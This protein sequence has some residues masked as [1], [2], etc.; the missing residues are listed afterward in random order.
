ML[1]KFGVVN[2]LEESSVLEY[3]F[4]HW[5]FPVVL[6]ECSL[7]IFWVSSSGPLGCE[8]EG[9]TIL[10]KLWEPLAQQRNGKSQKT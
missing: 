8:G 5:V 10:E 3:F 4:C 6:K 7:F 9:I 1:C 2:I